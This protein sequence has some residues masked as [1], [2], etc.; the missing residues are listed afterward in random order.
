MKS[1]ELFGDE[2]KSAMA[3]SKLD[4]QF[5]GA[6]RDHQCFLHAH[7]PT[8]SIIVATD[9]EGNLAVFEITDAIEAERVAYA[10]RVRDM[11]STMQRN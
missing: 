3:T 10:R 9:I 11:P 5:A 4:I 8:R 2:L 1:R 6:P 7:G